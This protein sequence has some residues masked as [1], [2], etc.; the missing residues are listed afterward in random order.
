MVHLE[1]IDRWGAGPSSSPLNHRQHYLARR[2]IQQDRV[3]SSHGLKPR[4]GELIEALLEGCKV[5]F[6]CLALEQPVDV[7]PVHSEDGQPRMIAERGMT[8]AP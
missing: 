3:F 6:R 4:K 5:H 1:R 8:S 7:S 2:Q